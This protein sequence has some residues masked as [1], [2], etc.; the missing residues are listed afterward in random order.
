MRRRFAVPA[1]IT[2]ALCLT[3]L[4]AS[5][6]LAV[7][8]TISKTTFSHLTTNSVLLEVEVNPQGIET[9]YHFEYGTAEC[10]VTPKACTKV[11]APDGKIP[12]GTSPV[13]VSA[14]V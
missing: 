7:A 1:A 14:K 12:P 3:A 13:S 2:A 11:P 6:A 4:G 10:S 8:P 9:F 5:S